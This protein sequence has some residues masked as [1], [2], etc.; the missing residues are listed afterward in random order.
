MLCLSAGA[1]SSV[2][3]PMFSPT[4]LSI[5]SWIPC[6]RD[7]SFMQGKVYVV[8]DYENNVLYG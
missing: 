5:S 3:G 1:I 6:Y 7:L 8:N 4:Q 2:H